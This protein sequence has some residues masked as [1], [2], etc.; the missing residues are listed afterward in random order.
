MCSY[1]DNPEA[2]DHCFQ[3]QYIEFCVFRTAEMM[4]EQKRPQ[5]TRIA[6]L[7]ASIRK[8]NNL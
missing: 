3:L 2:E 7:K 5:M 4:S 8:E 1:F 6:H